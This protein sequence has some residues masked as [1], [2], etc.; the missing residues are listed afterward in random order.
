MPNKLN[1]LIEQELNAKFPAGSD[2]VVVGYQ[3]LTGTETAEL[4]RLLRESKLQM[5]V[6]KNTI[7][8]RVLEKNGLGAG[9]NF[10]EG[11]C[12][13]VSGD[14]EMPVLCKVLSECSKK[15]ENR[16][17]IRGGVMDNMAISSSGVV[18]LA[19]IPPMPVLH[20]R[21]VGSVQAPIARV[22]GAFQAVLRSLACALEGIR[23]KKASSG[24]PPV[25]EAAASGPATGAA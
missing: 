24:P 22:A 7:A 5:E 8:R 6:V 17:T 20:A 14:V 18:G 13:I 21:I 23:E 11:P 25:P 4:R 9:A 19:E 10:L 15:L 12:A 1:R 2:F 16:F 3:K